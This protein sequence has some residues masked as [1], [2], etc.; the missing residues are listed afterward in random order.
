MYGT[1]RNANISPFYKCAVDPA[2]FELDERVV[3]D[4]LGLGGDA[5]VAVARLRRLLA[6]DPWI[7]SFKKPELR[8]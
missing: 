5:A 3:R 7:H 2:R 6:S 1:L 4:M 8:C